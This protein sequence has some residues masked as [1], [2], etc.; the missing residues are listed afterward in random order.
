MNRRTLVL[1]WLLILALTLVSQWLMA[2]YT[3]DD[4]FIS[5]RYARNVARGEGWVYNPRALDRRLQQLPV[6]PVPRSLLL[7]A[8]RSHD[9]FSDSGRGLQPRHT[10]PG[11]AADL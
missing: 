9:L 8:P 1:C 4:A 2:G 3:M 7:A 5:F 6:D 10:F 11:V